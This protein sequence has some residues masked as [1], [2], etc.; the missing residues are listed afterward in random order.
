MKLRKIYTEQICTNCL[1]KLVNDEGDHTDEELA[2]MKETL[3]DWLEQDYTPAGLTDDTEPSFSWRKCIL[4]GSA[5]GD[6]YSYHFLGT[7]N[8]K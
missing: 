5:A 1:H 2:E 4:C 7:I 6:R 3:H 8:T